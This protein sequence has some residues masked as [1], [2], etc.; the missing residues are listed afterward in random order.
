MRIYS[1]EVFI[2]R[3]GFSRFK[4]FPN[5]S[6]GHPFSKRVWRRIYVSSTL[7]VAMRR[8]IACAPV[9]PAKMKVIHALGGKA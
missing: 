4:C 7:V 3:D 1:P 5:D 8:W 2:Y 9:A 6:E